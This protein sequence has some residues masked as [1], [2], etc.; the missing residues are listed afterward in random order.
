MTRNRYQSRRSGAI[1]A[2]A[3]L[4]LIPMLA[5]VALCVD[6]GYL[7]VVRTDLQRAADAAALAAVRDLILAHLFADQHDPA[8]VGVGP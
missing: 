8:T 3:A 5:L 1:A 6:Y 7:L 2:L 4:L